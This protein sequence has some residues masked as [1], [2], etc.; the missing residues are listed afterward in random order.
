MFVVPIR[1]RTYV[2]GSLLGACIKGVI[3]M[4]YGIVLLPL[5]LVRYLAR[6]EARR[7][8]ATAYAAPTYYWHPQYGWQV[9]AYA[10]SSA[11]QTGRW[12]R[13]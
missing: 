6:R 4:A 12:R 9:A 10:T 3:L 8:T 13:R 5:A 7:S 11:V 2:V 1:P